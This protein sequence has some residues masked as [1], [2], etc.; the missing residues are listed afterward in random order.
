[1]PSQ[2]PVHSHELCHFDWQRGAERAAIPSDAALDPRPTWHWCIGRS[3]LSTLAA[4]VTATLG[5][6]S[7]PPLPPDEQL[8]LIKP[9]NANG[10]TIIPSTEPKWIHE[11]IHGATGE[12]IAWAVPKSLDSLQIGVEWHD[13]A[14]DAFRENMEV[15]AQMG[16]FFPPLFLAGFALIAD[17]NCEASLPLPPQGE[18]GYIIEADWQGMADSA[19]VRARAYTENAVNSME[20]VVPCLHNGTPL[21]RPSPVRIDDTRQPP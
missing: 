11:W 7:T 20:I 1:M 12:G 14:N 10:W 6:A 3:R 8:R 16:M 2:V 19:R 9:I 21:R 17:A 18:R 5:C 4:L 13:P 15:V